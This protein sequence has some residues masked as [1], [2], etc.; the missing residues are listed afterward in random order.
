MEDLTKKFARRAEEMKQRGDAY[1][2]QWEASSANQSAET[3]Q[4]YADRKRSYDAINGFM[5]DARQNF[6][7]FFKDVTEIKTLLQG[8]RD[9][10][11]IAQAKQLGSQANWR[12]IDTQRALMNIEDQFDHLADSFAAESGGQSDKAPSKQ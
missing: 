12:C 9:Q 8:S 1:F 10:K 7:S 6:L 3:R 11:S 4:R 5:Q 2:A